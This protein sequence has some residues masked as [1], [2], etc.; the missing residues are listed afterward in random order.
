[1]VN[2][3]M[4]TRKTSDRFVLH[5]ACG[6][7]I[8]GALLAA[9][10]VTAAA[11]A[12]A[13]IAASVHCYVVTDH[14]AIGDG[15]TVNTRA[16][17]AAID[18]RGSGVA[19]VSIVFESRSAESS[20]LLGRYSQF[21]AMFFCRNGVAGAGRIAAWLVRVLHEGPILTGKKRAKKTALRP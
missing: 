11:F 20:A 10:L 3:T 16:L 8:V 2:R 9:W 6:V 13:P 14:G 12:A 7:W 4:N 18:R 1:M 5:A 17:Q 15:A 21:W 19:K